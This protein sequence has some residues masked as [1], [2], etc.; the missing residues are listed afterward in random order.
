[1]NQKLDN[2]FENKIME[3]LKTTNN[4]LLDPS[5]KEKDINIIVNDLNLL[6][7]SYHTLNNLMENNK[8]EIIEKN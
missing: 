5:Y 4:N 8:K 7:Q 1:M 3:Q 2:E 6:L